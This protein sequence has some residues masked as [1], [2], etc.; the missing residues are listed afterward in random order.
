[1][2]SHAIFPPQDSYILHFWGFRAHSHCFFTLSEGPPRSLFSPLFRGRHCYLGISSTWQV[3][4]A[5]PSYTVAN[6][7]CLLQVLEH[8]FILSRA[9]YAVTA[10]RSKLAWWD[11]TYLTI[12]NILCRMLQGPQHPRWWAHTVSCVLLKDLSYREENRYGRKL[13]NEKSLMELRKPH[14]WSDYQQ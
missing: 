3:R 8:S 14:L 2:S 13:K 4:L 1:M 10:N 12:S 9:I 5:P 7:T 11:K 6:A